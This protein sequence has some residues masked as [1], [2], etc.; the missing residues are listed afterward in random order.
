MSEDNE[1]QTI[2]VQTILEETYELSKLDR[3]QAAGGLLHYVDTLAIMGK[4]NLIV[5]LIK[6]LDVTKVPYQILL[7]T[8]MTIFPIRT[9][10]NNEYEI[11]FTNVMKILRV[12]LSDERCDNITIRFQ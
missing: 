4:F 5:S 2:L 12:Q 10:L 7:G 1:I 6:M 9:K 8:L 11:F 3:Y